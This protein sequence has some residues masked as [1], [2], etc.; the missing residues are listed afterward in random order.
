MPIDLC[1]PMYAVVRSWKNRSEK[2]KPSYEECIGTDFDRFSRMALIEWRL[3]LMFS[4]I[5]SNIPSIWE[6]S[7][8]G[9]ARYKKGVTFEKYGLFCIQSYRIISPVL[10]FYFYCSAV[11]LDGFY[12]QQIYNLKTISRTYCSKVSSTT[13]TIIQTALKGHHSI[14]CEC[15]FRGWRLVVQTAHKQ[16]HDMFNLVLSFY[17]KTFETE[18]RIFWW[19]VSILLVEK[20]L[21]AHFWCGIYC[22]C[23]MWNRIKM[24]DEG[25]DLHPNC[26]FRFRFLYAF[27][28]V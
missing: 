24:F 11:Q 2:T 27:D 23:S 7:E 18:K 1:I 22:D 14:S 15:F 5:A 25:H 9:G 6:C 8:R 20:H 4:R 16:K 12:W 21:L 10:H 13:L 19:I 28:W 17:S 3:S 26:L